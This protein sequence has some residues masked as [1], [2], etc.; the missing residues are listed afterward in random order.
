MQFLK[1]MKSFIF[2]VML[3]FAVSLPQAGAQSL[4]ADLFSEQQ[5]FSSEHLEQVQV[6]HTSLGHDVLLIQRKTKMKKRLLQKPVMEFAEWSDY[7]T[8]PDK[9]GD[10]RWGAESLPEPLKNLL[11]LRTFDSQGQATPVMAN[12]TMFV[13]V[14]T[15]AT[16]T[17]VFGLL[18]KQIQ[19]QDAQFRIVNFYEAHGL[20][21][22]KEYL[23]R[24]AFKSELPLAT[25]GHLFEHD[26]N[27]HV[28]SSLILPS[29]AAKALRARVE[30]FL[31][32][33]KYAES[34]AFSSKAEAELKIDLEKALLPELVERIDYS[35]GNLFRA[36]L[37]MKGEP[38]HKIM[39]E[40]QE[41][42]EIA[43]MDQT[44]PAAYLKK[45]LD[46]PQLGTMLKTVLNDY[47]VQMPAKYQAEDLPA[48][49]I[50]NPAELYN[51]VHSNVKILSQAA[52]QIS[53]A[54]A[55]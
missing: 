31:D 47:L 25:Q 8:N 35:T 50:R 28:Y 21:S 19:K 12:E 53:P 32:F 45:F 3:S 18:E 43:F 27:F 48:S 41:L 39:G 15:A 26:L 49:F 29:P 30:L 17:K 44:S 36:A 34:R 37:R 22:G 23:E 2:A 55:K 9:P 52:E 20:L 40:I 7:K 6:R 10:I 14:P 38:I 1:L 16:V 5:I 13:Q 4:C 24:F 42:H 11:G 54:S 46:R 33:M 51:D